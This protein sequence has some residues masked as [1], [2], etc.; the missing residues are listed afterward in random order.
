MAIRLHFVA[1]CFSPRRTRRSPFLYFFNTPD[2]LERFFAARLCRYAD[3][4][5]EMECF[6]YINAKKDT[7]KVF[8]VELMNTERISTERGTRI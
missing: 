4:I 3:R 2:E 6:N 1:I 7:I 5:D 8:I